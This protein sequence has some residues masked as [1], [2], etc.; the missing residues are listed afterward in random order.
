MVS[1]ETSIH[2]IG[3]AVGI[4]PERLSIGDV[5]D[6]RIP[7]EGTPGYQV[8]DLRT[9]VRYSGDLVVLLVFENLT[10]TRYKTHGSGVYGA[11]RTVLSS[12]RWDL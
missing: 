7:A 8:F 9:G 2:R 10:D 11:G 1:P 4:E 12:I 5:A 3:D 6:A